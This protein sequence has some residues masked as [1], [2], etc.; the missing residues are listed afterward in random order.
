MSYPLTFHVNGLLVFLE[1]FQIE[2]TRILNLEAFVPNIERWKSHPVDFV[3]QTCGVCRQAFPF[4]SSPPLP[5]PSRSFF[6]LV[7]IWRDQK[8]KCLKKAEKSTEVLVTQAIGTHEVRHLNN[9][10]D[11][12]IACDCHW[13]LSQ[14]NSTV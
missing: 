4:L 13:Q 11:L 8:G 2:E 10:H 14:V 9:C 5:L 3:F 12:Q 6:A 1:C 7:L